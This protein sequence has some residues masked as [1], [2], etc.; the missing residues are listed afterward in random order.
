[1]KCRHCS[2]E[3]D[4]ACLDLGTAPPSNSYLT[5]AQLSLPES[6]FPLRLLLCQSCYLVQTEDFAQRESLFTEDY[7][8]FS[9]Y[10][11]SWLAHAQAYVQA[12][13]ERFSLNTESLV[14]EIAA[15]D[16]YLLQYVKA[17]GIPCY[18]IEPTTS[19]AAVA[20]QRGIAIIEEFFGETLGSQL[21][22]QGKQ[23]DLIAANNV[24]AHVPDINDFVRGF[25]CLLKP[26]GVATFEFPHLLNMVQQNQ[27]DTAYHEHYSYLSLTAVQ[28]IFE[29]NGL[30]VFDVEQLNTH[31]GS[32]RVYAQ[33]GT[34]HTMSERVADCLQQ[35]KKVGMLGRDFYLGFQSNAE[36]AKYTFVETLIN[37]KKNGFKVVGYGAAAKGNTL[38]NFS[39]LRSDL[40]Q[41]VA[42]KNPQKQNKFL[43]GS[44]IPIVDVS[45]IAVLKPDRIILFPWNL[46][47]ELV[48]ELSYVR[49]WGCKFVLAI[50]DL[51][52]L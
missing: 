41:F 34:Y 15:N 14:A 36:R 51:Y 5:R 24:L 45:N 33:T 52:E 7:A 49:D 40:I 32:L 29:A 21:R 31:G 47:S 16:G 27:F 17:Q 4:L 46:K 18:G 1:M 2:S 28:K 9:S 50:P 12:M 30:Q 37:Y 25:A 38:L 8:Y 35:E 43:P 23:A 13:Q 44:R 48:S 11:S 10:S 22:E 6:Y 39:G 20:K 26:K 42:D 19:T 3:L